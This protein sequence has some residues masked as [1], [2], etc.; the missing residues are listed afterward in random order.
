MTPLVSTNATSI[1]RTLSKYLG[2]RY[3]RF[4]K[5]DNKKLNLTINVRSQSEGDVRKT[6]RSNMLHPFIFIQIL[7]TISQ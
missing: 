4:L 2:A 5:P 7:E 6:G 3:R 1:T